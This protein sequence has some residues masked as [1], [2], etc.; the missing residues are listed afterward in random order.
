MVAPR[1]QIE[2]GKNDR[3]G[4]GIVPTANEYCFRRDRQAARRQDLANARIVQDYR[5]ARALGPPMLPEHAP[6]S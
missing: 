5:Q 6:Q 2:V 3:I 1:Q 4:R